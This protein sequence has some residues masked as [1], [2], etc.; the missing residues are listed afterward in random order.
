MIDL[1]N[2]SLGSFVKGHPNATTGKAMI[3][4]PGAAIRLCM[5][6]K[7]QDAVGGPHSKKAADEAVKTFGVTA[8]RIA[9]AGLNPHA[10]EG[11][12]FGGEDTAG[13]RHLRS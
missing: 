13:V 9:V 3:E 6:K 12:I 10:G 8:P 7:V 2:I 5:E 4:Y 11:G 1:D